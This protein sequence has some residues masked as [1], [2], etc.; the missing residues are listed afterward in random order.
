ME[1]KQKGKTQ[2]FNYAAPDLRIIALVTEDVMAV[3]TQIGDPDFDVGQD[4]IDV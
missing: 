1:T 4:A 2:A 3:S